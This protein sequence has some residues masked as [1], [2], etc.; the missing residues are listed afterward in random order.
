[1]LKESHAIDLARSLSQYPDVVAN[2][3]KTQEPSTML[4]YLFKMSHALSSSYDI[5]QVVGSEPELKRARLA[6]YEAARQVLWNGM[7]LLGLTPV[8]RM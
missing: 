6:L 5:L 7:T 2:T 1:M 8:K 3:L 4:T